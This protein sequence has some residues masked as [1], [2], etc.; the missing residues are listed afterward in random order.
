M[1][2]PREGDKLFVTT[3]A[4]D[5]YWAGVLQFEPK[6]KPDELRVARYASGAWT[7]T[8]QRWTTFDKELRAILNA[9]KRFRIF[10]LG[11]FTLQTDS[12]A[13]I[14]FLMKPSLDETRSTKQI[15]DKLGILIFQHQMSVKHIPG[16]KNFI[17]DSL[18]RALA[19]CKKVPSSL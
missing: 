17:A 19:T 12:K 14:G 8:E 2:L 16:S 15:R 11:N 7:P 13:V 10:L 6:D 9:L 5:D 1:E 3:N 4:N 18:T